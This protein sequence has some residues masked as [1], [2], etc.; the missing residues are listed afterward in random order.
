MSYYISLITAMKKREDLLDYRTLKRDLNLCVYLKFVLSA[1]SCYCV[2]P[3][4]HARDNLD[5]TDNQ[6]LNDKR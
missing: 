4:G 5:V 1:T 3:V 6:V 2:L